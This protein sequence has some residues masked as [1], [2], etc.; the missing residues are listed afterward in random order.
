[1]RFRVVQPWGPDETRQS[2]VLSEHETVAAAFEEIERLASQMARTGAPSDAI[3]LV[4]VDVERNVLISRPD[5][6]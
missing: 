5:A 1:M 6:H 2:T 4:V 3:T